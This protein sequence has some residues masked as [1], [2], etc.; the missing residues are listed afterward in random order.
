MTQPVVGLSESCR[1]ALALL[2]LA[3]AEYR[4]TTS[5]GAAILEWVRRS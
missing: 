5:V 4:V 3:A 1:I 2:E